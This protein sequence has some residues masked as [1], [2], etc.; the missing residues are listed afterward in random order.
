[1]SKYLKL[2]ETTS[3]YEAY[4]NGGGVILPNVSVAKD[5]PKTMYFNPIPLFVKLFLNNGEVVE[6]QGS[7]ELTYT[8]VS[9][10]KSSVV[11]AEIGKSCTS[12]GTYAFSYCSGLTSITIPNSVIS[13]DQ[14]AFE[15]CTGLTSI[16]IPD[17]VTIIECIFTNTCTQFT[18]FCTDNR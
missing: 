17:S 10:Y 3:E 18:N 5:A 7:G 15:G 12:I 4:I 1:M 14:G 2:F 16:T 13:I 9:P 6:L 11:S 8:M